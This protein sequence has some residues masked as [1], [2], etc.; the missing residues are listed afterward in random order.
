MEFKKLK[1]NDE[2]DQRW[3]ETLMRSPH[4]RLY[5]LTSMLDAMCPD[6]EPYADEKNQYIFPL[7]RFKK[8]LF[9]VADQPFF[10]QQL[11]VFSE[12]GSLPDLNHIFNHLLRSMRRVHIFFHA[13]WTGSLETTNGFEISKRVNYIL[14]LQQTYI[15]IQKNYNENTKR[16]LKKAIWSEVK[17]ISGSQYVQ[18]AADAGLFEDWAIKPRHL[19]Q[20]LSGL[21]QAKK[22]LS[23]KIEA[24]YH[25]G[26]I[27]AAGILVYFGN[28]ITYI[29]GGSSGSGTDGKAMF[30]LINHW[31]QQH[32]GSDWTL[33]FEGSNIPGVARFFAGFGAQRED[34]LQVRRAKFPFK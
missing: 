18:F 33:D 4:A 20:L 11:G 30:V 14:P 3:N 15:G 17:E 9:K 1:R 34:Y 32:A 28:R 31:I 5:A 13:G 22:Y 8:G 12:N 29:S 24:V 26:Q 21:N 25:D 7:T 19:L 10:L 23:F 16:N 2:L 6:W 27:M